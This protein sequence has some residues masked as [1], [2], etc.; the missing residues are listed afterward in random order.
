MRISTNSLRKISTGGW[1]D[2]SIRGLTILRPAAGDI[3]STMM[4]C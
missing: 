2:L 3:V 4:H 1:A